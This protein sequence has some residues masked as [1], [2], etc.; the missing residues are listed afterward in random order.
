[1]KN[2]IRYNCSN[3]DY[4]PGSISHDY[5][6]PRHREHVH[7]YQPFHPGTSTGTACINVVSNL[8]QRTGFFAIY[9]MFTNISPSNPIPVQVQPASI[10]SQIQYNVL[11]FAIDNMFTNIRVFSPLPVQAQPASLVQNTGILR[12]LY[13]FE[14][15]L[16]KPLTLHGVPRTLFIHI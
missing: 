2:Y 6:V 8:V 10:S 1:M 3:F 14:G 15:V 16:F 5:R 7:Q 12:F 4:L 11:V 13:L 9:N